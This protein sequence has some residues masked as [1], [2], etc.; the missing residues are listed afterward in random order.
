MLGVLIKKELFVE[1]RNKE[2][3]F[4]MLAFGASVL[5]IF[6][7]SLSGNPKMMHEIAPGLF[8]T[9]VLLSSSLGLHRM[10]GLEKDFDAFSSLI[11]SPIDRSILFLSKWISG[12]IYLSLTELLIIT[13]FFLFLGLSKPMSI[14]PG[15]GIVL[16]GNLGITA[17]GVLISGIAMRGRMSAVLL[18]VLLF[19]LLTPLLI[20][21]VK[22]TVGWFQVKPF[23]F[24]QIWVM[25]MIT[26]VVIFSL[27]GY[28]LFDQITEE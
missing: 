7:F 28:T 9:L 21:C 5:L 18:P 19:P 20:A 11:A 8:W 23:E 25:I 17:V 12:F 4:S 14:L 27:A 15:I 6:S 24:Y 3:V 2:V 16:C 13:P 1:L 10:F 22:S 26:Y